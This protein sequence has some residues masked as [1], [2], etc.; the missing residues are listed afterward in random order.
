MC[1]VLS[2]S[3]DNLKKEIIIKALQNAITSRKPGAGLIFHSDRGSQYASKDF[4]GLLADNKIIPSMNGKSNC[5]DNAKKESFFHTLKTE[6]VY[7][8]QYQTRMEAQK[9]IFE[10][11]EIFYNRKRLHSSLDYCS[12][13][14]FEK[15][16]NTPFLLC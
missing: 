16:T 4:R 9:S 15:L 6:L 13:V 8:E 2:V 14:E 3:S 12:P 5:Y 10:Y 7:F 1:K 11:I